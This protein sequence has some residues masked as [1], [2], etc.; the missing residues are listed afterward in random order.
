MRK[1][2]AFFTNEAV[3]HKTPLQSEYSFNKIP[4]YQDVILISTK[5]VDGAIYLAIEK[6]T[7]APEK[8]FSGFNYKKVTQDELK[9]A[10]DELLI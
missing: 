2:N 3:S 8:P 6:T 1:Y 4:A 10:M 5:K 9:T 7:T